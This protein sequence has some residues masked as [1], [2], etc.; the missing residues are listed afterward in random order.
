MPFMVYRILILS[1]GL[2]CLMSVVSLLVNYNRT[3]RPNASEP[4]ECGFERS[5]SAR[6]PFSLK[7][8]LIVIIFLIFDVE[9]AMLLP[10][11]GRIRLLVGSTVPNIGLIVL[12]ILVVGLGLEG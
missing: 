9:V 10:V 4:F 7:Y 8:Y 3:I 2:P 6:V 12:M 1:V 5:S 11:P